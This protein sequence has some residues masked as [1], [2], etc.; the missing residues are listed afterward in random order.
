MSSIRESFVVGLIGDGITETLS[1]PLH[2]READRQGLRYVYRPVDLELLPGGGARAMELM[3]AGF[4]LG[5]NAFNITH[6]W[7]QRVMAELDEVEEEARRVGAVNTVVLR[8]GKKV[9]HNTDCSGFGAGLDLVLPGADLR[10]VL[11]LGAGGAGGATACALLQRGTGRLDLFDLDPARARERAETLSAQ[12]PEAE[13]RAIG[14]Q[15]VPGS[16]RAATGLLNA[17]P[18]GMHHLP[19]TPLDPDLLHP[20]LW[21]GEVVYLPLETPLLRHARSLGCA[22]LPGGAMAVGQAV[23]AFSLITGLRPDAA[24]MRADFAQLA[25]QRMGQRM[26]QRMVRPWSL[27]PDPIPS[28]HR[29]GPSGPGPEG[30]LPGAS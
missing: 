29:T 15:Q 26:G 17:S 10:H 7:K 3:H 20:G 28:G 16:V 4:D 1:A 11:Q 5:F 21:V 18:V 8:E 12:F 30:H 23:D 27:S 9:G 22:V 25:A 13:V 6:P 14:P 2:E 19:G 24:A